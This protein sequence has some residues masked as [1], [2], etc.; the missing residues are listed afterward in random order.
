MLV[1]LI[2]YLQSKLDLFE[3]TCFIILSINKLHRKHHIFLFQ[4]LYA[5]TRKYLRGKYHCTIDLLFDLFGL[6]CFANKNK[7]CQLPY[8]W[9]QTSQTGGQWYSDTSPFSIPCLHTPFPKSFFH[10]HKH[11]HTH[12]HTHFPQ[13]TLTYI[14]QPHISHTIFIHFL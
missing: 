12:T 8:S 11:T 13:T 5:Y 4:Y 3:A 2:L 14:L 10:T 9:F 6:A 1:C 7:K